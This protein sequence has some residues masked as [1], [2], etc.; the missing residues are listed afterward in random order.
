MLKMKS[1]PDSLLK[2]KG[3]KKCSSEFVENK[4][5]TVFF[6]WLYDI[7]GVSDDFRCGRAGWCCG[8]QMAGPPT[9]SRIGN[10]RYQARG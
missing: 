4:L 3:Q 1:A 5:V 8:S 2:K 6:L 9:L 7:E 10:R